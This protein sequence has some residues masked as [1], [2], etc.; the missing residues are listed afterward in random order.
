[1]IMGGTRM[2]S[3]IARA[4]SKRGCQV[5]LTWRR[6]RDSAEK[7]VEEIAAM[8][9]TA[10]SV[11]C[12]LTRESDI[13]R[14]ARDVY[15]RFGRLDVV[16]NL[17]S[18]YERTPSKPSQRKKDWQAHLT[19][20]AESA[21]L[22]SLAAAP[23]MK[24]SGGGRLIHISDWTAVS[25]RPRYSDYSAYYVSKVSVKAVV[26]ALALEFA[27]SILINA[28]APGPILPPPNM[29][30]SELKTVEQATPLKRW[31]GVD[32]IVKAVMFLIDTDFVTGETIRVDGGR[33]LY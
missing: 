27:P 2:G 32:E 24:Q 22:L 1:M 20:N 6:S 33:H 18:L 11:R 4:L 13:Q 19:A 25:G 30:K 23:W 10:W 14:M 21:Y 7:A 5:V 16:V 17:A 12:D 8:G 15:K 9:G 28:I 3:A 31:G 26:E 29:T